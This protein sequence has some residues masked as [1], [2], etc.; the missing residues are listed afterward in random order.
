M[1]AANSN[2]SP[3]RGIAFFFNK[4]DYNHTRILVAVVVVAAAAAA[5]LVV[6]VVRKS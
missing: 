2:T 3:E 1:A 4:L 6:V 5:A